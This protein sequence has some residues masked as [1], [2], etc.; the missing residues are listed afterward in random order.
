MGMSALS[1]QKA[2]TLTR[3]A[4]IAIALLIVGAGTAMAVSARSASKIDSPPS[5]LVLPVV[6]LGIKKADERPKVDV[7]TIS[8]A[9][10]FAAVSNHPKPVDKP[11]VGAT[12]NAPA[13]P[14]PSELKYLGAVGMGASKVALVVEGGKQRFVGEGDSLA[15]GTI[16]SISDSEVK[17]GGSVSKT[18]AL[19]SRS[20]DV[21]TRTTRAPVPPANAARAGMTPGQLGELQAVPRTA[22]PYVTTTPTEDMAYYRNK[23]GVP[24]YVRP[25]E[26]QDF[27]SIR[28]ELRSQEKFESEDEL[29]EIA[30]KRWEDKKGT[31]PELIRHRKEAEAKRKAGEK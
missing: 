28:E 1:K 14:A 27:I 5:T 30:S 9:D 8:T 16:Q 29:N 19:A 10:R 4:Q 23:N 11:A 21:L 17:V 12:P 18:I 6:D 13:A 25:G 2:A 3:A 24:D 15:G 26:E 31:S 20:N 7:D 22:Q